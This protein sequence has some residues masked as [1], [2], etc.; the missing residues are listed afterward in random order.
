MKQETLKV[1]GCVWLGMLCISWS[2]TRPASASE[3]YD[4]AITPGKS[5]HPSSVVVTVTAPIVGSAVSSSA[6][7]GN[8]LLATGSATEP[9]EF[10][11][12]LEAVL[13]LRDGISF[14]LPGF[15][16]EAPPGGTR[17]RMLEPG[18]ASATTGGKFDQLENLFDFEGVIDISTQ[19]TPFDLSQVAPITTDL[20]DIQLGQE[21]EK[22]T[23]NLGFDLHFTAAVATPLGQLPIEINVLGKLTAR[24][25]RRGDFDGNG[26]LDVHDME[27]LQRGIRE[28]NAQFDLD[29]NGVADFG[30]LAEWVENIKKTYFGDTN[31]DGIFDTEDFVAAFVGGEYLDGVAGNSTWATGDWDGNGDFDTEDI[32]LAFTKGG[33]LMEPRAVVHSVPEFMNSV[34]LLTCLLLV[35]RRDARKRHRQ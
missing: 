14:N 20:Y 17:V 9:Y 7:T 6:L 22:L 15:S 10:G 12:L 27:V 19:N 31:L 21:D 30:D 8:V 35:H 24:A 26:V 13:E 2:L 5:P 4:M 16:V 25:N 1:L 34:W 23:L 18:P 32:V 29:Q 3:I 33:F 11:H 28:G